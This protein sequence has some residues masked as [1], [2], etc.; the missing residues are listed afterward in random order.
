MRLL[1]SR[2]HHAD[3]VH[4]HGRQMAHTRET[5]VKSHTANPPRA[6]LRGIVHGNQRAG[7]LVGAAP[8]G[9]FEPGARASGG[10]V[11]AP[12][13]QRV[14]GRKKP[15]ALVEYDLVATDLIVDLNEHF[16]HACR[17]DGSRTCKN[18]VSKSRGGATDMSFS[19]W[20]TLPRW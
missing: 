10:L 16:G 7:L 17:R 6:H 14:H 8:E 3:D 12:L 5:R 1:R 15:L 13:P 18:L 4:Q 20:P 11:S 9:V 2:P 19:T